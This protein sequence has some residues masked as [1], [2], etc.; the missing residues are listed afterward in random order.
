MFNITRRLLKSSNIYSELGSLKISTVARMYLLDSSLLGAINRLAHSRPYSLQCTELHRPQRD[1][2][3]RYLFHQPRGAVTLI[4]WSS[5][6]GHCF[7][8]KLRHAPPLSD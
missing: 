5:R 2:T 6:G 3:K 4:E 1:N 7:I 8:L